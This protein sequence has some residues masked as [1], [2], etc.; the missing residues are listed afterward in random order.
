MFVANVLIIVIVNV[1]KNKCKPY[2]F[3]VYNAL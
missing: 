1:F 3:M 2:F